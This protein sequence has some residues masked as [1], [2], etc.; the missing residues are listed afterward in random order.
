MR[1]LRLIHTPT[2]NWEAM[3]SFYELV[4][5]LPRIEGWDEPGDRGVFLK[6]TGG[7]IELMEQDAEAL[8]LYPPGAG[9][10]L[11]IRVEDVDAEYE[12]L[13]ALNVP[14]PREITPRPWGARD[15]LVQDP[16]GNW[17]LLF[18]HDAHP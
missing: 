9:W 4:L 1:S 10:R 3:C 13:A 2:P 6:L 7:E 12:R 5:L 15:F 14:L 11:A 16:A 17:I 18:Q 8:G